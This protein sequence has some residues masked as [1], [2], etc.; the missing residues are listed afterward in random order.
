[1]T[2]ASNDRPGSGFSVEQQL[3]GKLGKAGY[4]ALLDKLMKTTR[5]ENK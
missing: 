3:I 1:M 5:K 4:G 2:H